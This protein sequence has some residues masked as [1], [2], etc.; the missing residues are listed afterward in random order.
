MANSSQ[1]HRTSVS[2][3][4]SGWDTMESLGPL[5]RVLGSCAKSSGDYPSLASLL[6]LMSEPHKASVV[7][8]NGTAAFE[9]APF[10][11]A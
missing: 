2:S 6:L 10:P 7:V 5:N 3:H 8:G 11:E 9:L 4:T 1:S